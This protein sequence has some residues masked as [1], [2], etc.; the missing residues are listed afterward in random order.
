MF[1]YFYQRCLL[2]TAQA[3]VTG[4]GRASDNDW[5]M[6][7]GSCEFLHLVLR[8]NDFGTSGGYEV[9]VIW[10]WVGGVHGPQDEVMCT[11]HLVGTR[12]QGTKAEDFPG[13]TTKL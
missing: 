1:S 5:P 4:P 10:V 2:E 3:L 9:K 6:E 7:N 12:Y 11:G 13:D 8:G